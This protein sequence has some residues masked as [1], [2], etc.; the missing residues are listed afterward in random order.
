MYQ[1]TW[2]FTS[3]I[4]CMSTWNNMVTNVADLADLALMLRIQPRS[5]VRQDPM[6]SYLLTLP[7]AQFLAVMST[8]IS[9]LMLRKGRGMRKR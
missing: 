1:A 3:H 5:A 9:I 4:K 7:E 6:C 2:K 8:L